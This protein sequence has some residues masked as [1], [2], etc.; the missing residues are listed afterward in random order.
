MQDSIIDIINN[1]E[2][3]Q[4]FLLVTNDLVTDGKLNDAAVCHA[5]DLTFKNILQ[6]P[7]PLQVVFKDISKFDAQNP[8]IGSQI[9]S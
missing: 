2:D 8:I 5:L 3:L 1:R 7:N 4:K 9:E 6:Q